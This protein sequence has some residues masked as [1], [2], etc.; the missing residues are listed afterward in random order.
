MN[1]EIKKYYFNTF[2]IIFKL[3]KLM[4]TINIYVKYR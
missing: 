2:K 3:S 1:I 4:I